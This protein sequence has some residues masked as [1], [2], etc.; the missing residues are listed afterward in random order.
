MEGFKSLIRKKLILYLH[1]INYINLKF[2]MY[3]NTQK[4]KIL[5][6]LV[7]MIALSKLLT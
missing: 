2:G 1:S 4:M 7:Q 5:Y 3:I 6:F